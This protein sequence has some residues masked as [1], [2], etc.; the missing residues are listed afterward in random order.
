MF[1]TTYSSSPLVGVTADEIFPNIQIDGFSLGD[2]TI[3]AVMRAVLYDRLPDGQTAKLAY[4]VLP[5]CSL[6]AEII[7]DSFKD[8]DL[9]SVENHLLILSVESRNDEEKALVSHN[10]EGLS[11]LFGMTPRVEVAKTLSDAFR[12]KITM[13]ADRERS[14]TLFAI[15][16]SPTT[17]MLH[18]IAKLMPR[19]FD[20]FYEHDSKKHCV[21]T[22]FESRLLI[23]GLGTSKDADTFSSVIQEFCERFDFS[24]PK[25]KT[26]LKGIEQNF[27]KS[28]L[29]NL[30]QKIESLISRIT[31]TNRAYASLVRQKRD[32]IDRRRA[33]ELGLE[34]NSQQDELMNYFLTNR[35]LVLDEVKGDSISFDVRTV[36]ANF[37]SAAAEDLLHMSDRTSRSVLYTCGP[38]VS[39]SD[40]DLLYRAI[41][42]DQEIRVWMYG[43]FTFNIGSDV[44]VQA[45]SAREPIPEMHDCCPNPHLYFFSCMGD[46]ERYAIDA[47]L[48]GDFTVAMEQMIGA[49]ASANINESITMNRWVR[50][51][52][53]DSYGRFFETEDGQRMNFTEVMHYL[54]EGQ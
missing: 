42:V 5:S 12:T 43:H 16:G 32:F 6:D 21:L 28:Q 40:R 10:I 46:N 34:G 18:G 54:K 17:F 7:A 4:R 3:P 8:I 9:R 35:N 41:F 52:L 1:A 25:I 24:T 30:D 15:A 26:L 38:S 33:I 53:S 14:C 51:L 13:F 11:D 47:L 49:A 39:A 48:A 23:D 50:H 2:V 37:D 20:R 36:L 45:S 31:E 27:S 22:D 44:S 19:Y 29:A